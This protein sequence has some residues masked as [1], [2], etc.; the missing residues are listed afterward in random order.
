MSSFIV[1]PE[2]INRI[3]SYL[4]YAQGN[5][6]IQYSN[7]QCLLRKYGITVE[8]WIDKQAL[9]KKL[10]DLNIEAVHQR[11]GD[12]SIETMPGK[13]GQKL[14]DYVFQY[15]DGGPI[16]VYKSLQCLTY[17]CAEGNVPETELYRFLEDLE[18][19][20]AREIVH[21]M[22]EYDKAEWD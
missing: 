14:S 22:P 12:M 7:V 5:G 2:T 8:K 18:N 4:S 15:E 21:A 6:Q 16:R 10:I 3:V 11:Y 13:V 17:Q 1:R 20:I 9:V 19:T